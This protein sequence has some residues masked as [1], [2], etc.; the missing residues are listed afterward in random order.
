MAD[1]AIKHQNRN[2]YFDNVKFFLI[3]L[4]VV[5]H[6]IS[7]LKGQEDFLFDLYAMIY[8]FHM[9]AFI[10]ISGY[11]SKG[12]KKKGYLQ[13]TF[14]KILI[15][16]FIFQIFYSIFYYLNGDKG[17]SFELFSPHWTLW[18]LLS[19]FTWNVLLYVFGKWRWLGLF[20]ATAIG[21]GIGFIESVGTWMSLSRT[22]VFFPFFFLGFLLSKENF[23]KLKQ[24]KYSPHIGIFVLLSVF[25][26]VVEFF[27]EGGIPW[28]FGS[29]SYVEMGR[30]YVIDAAVRLA[31]YIGTLVVLVAFMAVVPNKEYSFTIIGQRTMS[32]YLL[33][34]IIIQLIQT[35]ISKSTLHDFAN[36]YALLIGLSLLICI[37]CG[38]YYSKKV[39]PI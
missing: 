2:P 34:G 25:I 10:L 16:Y 3:F 22:F 1:T 18:F 9:P 19:L 26:I 38:S 4:V 37:A 7:P 27:P 8:I 11:F 28:L 35:F 13:K 23:E 36:N 20:I 33:H 30:G 17:L 39:L 14:K 5:G 6:V 21:V 32:I 24:Y 29:Q 15:P 31:Q 12:Y